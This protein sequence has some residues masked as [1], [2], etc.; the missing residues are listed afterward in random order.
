MDHS[1][2]F[3]AIGLMIFVWW[4]GFSDDQLAGSLPDVTDLLYGA[5]IDDVNEVCSAL[6]DS[7]S[8]S[9]QSWR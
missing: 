1:K 8:L 6:A 7:L 3:L 5:K 9:P 4:N 2:L